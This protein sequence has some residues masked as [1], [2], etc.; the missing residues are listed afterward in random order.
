MKKFLSGLFAVVLTASSILA[1]TPGTVTTVKSL[2]AN[3]VD[4][5]QIQSIVATA[6]P[7]LVVS[8]VNQHDGQIDIVA[9]RVMT[10]AEI[11]AFRSACMAALFQVSHN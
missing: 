5:S 6:A 8:S 4:M 9:D 7:T 3:A 10:S 2:V 1:Q 11:T